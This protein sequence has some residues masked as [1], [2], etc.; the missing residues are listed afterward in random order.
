M[1]EN[2]NLLTTYYDG[3]TKRLQIE[4]DLL[5]RLISHAGEKGRANEN[6]LI[7]LI[8]KFLPKRYSI[9]SGI[10]IDKDG[11]SSRQIDVIVYDSNFH[12]ELF[13]QGAATTSTTC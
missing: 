13:S 12:P 3:V 10:I 6:V 2:D 5:N 4:F 11:N 1:P 8:V 9:G 7:N